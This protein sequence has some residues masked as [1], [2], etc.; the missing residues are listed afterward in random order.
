MIEQKAKEM[1]INGDLAQD[2]AFCESTNRQ[3]AEDGSVLRGK[4]NPSD[5]GLFQINEKYHLEKSR[6][7]GFDIR[8]TEGN[9]GYA[10]WLIKREATRHWR[11][12][13]SCWRG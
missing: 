4:Q 5:L 8:A 11:S 12:S 1:G 9:I 7:L 13:K 10:M 6:E 3:F 2:I